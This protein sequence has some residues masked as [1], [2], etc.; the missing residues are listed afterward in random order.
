MAALITGILPVLLFLGGLLFMD[1]Y[2][3]VQRRDLVR[4]MGAGA[5]AAGISF[6]L[7][8]LTIQTF[9]GDPVMVRRY[10]A[11]LLEECFKASLVVY[12]IRAD[13]VGFMVDA[14]IHGFAVGT[15]FAVVENLYYAWTLGTSSL[16]L[17][18]VRGLGTA[19]LHGS[20]TAVVGILSKDL[21]ERHRS[22][23]LGWFVPGFAIAV[24]IHSLYNHLVINPL[25]STAALLVAMPL[26]VV[27]VYERSEHATRD[28]LGE[29][30]D[31]DVERLELLMSG[32]E[33]HS[34]IGEY[35]DSL[36]HRFSGAVLA[37]L[38]CLLRIHL[39]LSVRAK[40]VLIARAAGV[41]LPPDDEVRANLEELRYLERSIGNTGRL[42]MLPLL[43][44]SSRDL[45][46]IH[47][48]QRGQRGA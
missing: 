19:I 22:R 36:R 6:A 30:L 35:L 14:G 13:K 23:G 5:L 44:T 43:R 39:E 10:L 4:S 41:E 9:H 8:L 48:L 28:W 3:L 33:Q 20:T 12:F 47:M 40:G 11:P 45:W 46:Q 16:L 1:S 27:V 7:N 34:P 21:T 38:L 29:G 24:V 32:E 31:S 15:G 42:A 26:L 17:W 37:D 25:L 2:K 18:V